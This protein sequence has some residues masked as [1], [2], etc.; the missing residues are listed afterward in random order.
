[1][2]GYMIG[3]VVMLIAILV[4]RMVSDRA[5]KKLSAEE[6]AQ[7]IDAFSSNR[8]WS[9]ALMIL[10]ISGYFVVLR[11]EL[12]DVFVGLGIYITL[13]VAFIAIQAITS[14]KK[15][16]RL[17]LPKEYITSHNVSTLIRF[18]GFAAFFVL[19]FMDMY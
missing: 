17:G 11:F 1:M 18:A 3:L 13:L 14:H 15:L 6:K 16:A 8:T 10:L 4:S 5:T 7:L 2:D 12:V 19:L 9:L